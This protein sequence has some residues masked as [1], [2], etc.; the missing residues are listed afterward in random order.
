[1]SAFG[2]A[3]RRFQSWSL[4]TRIG[5]GLGLVGVVLAI[6]FWLFP[7]PTDLP[8]DR[9]VLAAPNLWPLDVAQSVHDPAADLY[10]TLLSVRN[11]DEYFST[12]PR[13]VAQLSDIVLGCDDWGSGCSESG[14]LQGHCFTCRV[15]TTELIVGGCAGPKNSGACYT[16]STH[17][18]IH[19]VRIT[20]VAAGSVVP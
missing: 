1:M 5:I 11:P 14:G 2:K 7:R 15:G 19:L 16:V 13:M 18:P 10:K 3:W 17:A 8:T 9:V 6:V 20:P 4:P 12:A